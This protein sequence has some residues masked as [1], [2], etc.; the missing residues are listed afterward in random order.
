VQ[1][2]PRHEK[3]VSGEL[4]T[5]DICCFLPVVPRVSQW[6]DRRRMIQTP[7]FPGYVFARLVFRSP[8]RLALLSTNGVVGLVGGGGFGTPIPEHEINAVQQIVE[9]GVA[10]AAHEELP[11]IGRRVRIRGGA[12][13][14]L[15]GILQSVKGDQS[16][17]VSIEAIRRSVSVTITGYCVEAIPE[18]RQH[19]GW[20][21]SNTM[22][23]T[24]SFQ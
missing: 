19:D 20:N 17:I 24:P 13:D 21:V 14:G 23:S 8:A 7:L 15:E 2:V 22:K 12:L 1:T 11:A 9:K 4:A 5:K 6:S 18:T 3:K 16:L 10:I